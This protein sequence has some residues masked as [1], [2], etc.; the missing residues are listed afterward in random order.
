[1][2]PYIS[3]IQVWTLDSLLVHC[4]SPQNIFLKPSSLAHFPADLKCIHVSFYLT[5]CKGLSFRMGRPLALRASTLATS[6]WRLRFMVRVWSLSAGG[7]LQKNT[8]TKKKLVSHL[9]MEWFFANLTRVQ[10]LNEFKSYRLE[11]LK[12]LK[13]Q[14]KVHGIVDA[15]KESWLKQTSRNS[16]SMISLHC[17][18]N[19]CQERPFSASRPALQHSQNISQPLAGFLAHLRIIFWTLL[20]ALCVP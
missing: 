17:Q 16:P 5:R 18:N 13:K 20:P 10:E 7:T 9:A 8:S 19:K 14:K 12:G 4:P 6:P 3:E 2:S 1:M 11:S 15:A